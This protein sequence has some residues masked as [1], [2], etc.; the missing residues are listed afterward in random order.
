MCAKVGVVVHTYIFVVTCAFKQV[1]AS[2]CVN[3]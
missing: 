3:V 2:L 1:S